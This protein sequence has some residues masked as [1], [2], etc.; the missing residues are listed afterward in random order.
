MAATR[1][2]P[3]EEKIKMD[4]FTNSDFNL[5]MLATQSFNNILEQIQSSCLNFQIQ[6][7]P[8]SAVISLKKSL[9][10]DQ[11]GKPRLPT[12]LDD[13][14]EHV[15]DLVTKNLELERKL[16]VLSNK[17]AE[18]INDFAK[19]KE[20][21]KDL[22]NLSQEACIKVEADTSEQIKLKDLEVELNLVKDIL[23]DRDDEILELEVALKAAKQAS[24]K[25]NS[26]LGQTRAKFE[27]EKALLLKEHRAEVKAWKKDLGNERK[28]RIKIEKEFEKVLGEN[29]KKKNDKKK[30][31]TKP[32]KLKL[33]PPTKINSGI[34]CSICATIIDNFQPDYFCGEMYNP[35]CQTCKAND[36]SWFQDDPFSSFPS[37]SQPPSLVSHWLLTSQQTLPQNPS[38][39][40][41]LV[42]HCAKLPNPGDIFLSME[43]I[44]ELM[45]E[46][47]EEMRD[48]FKL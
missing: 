23:K 37:D 20:T 19:Y 47:F 4:E 6:I 7:S 14:S 8:F 5:T 30:Q 1:T 36:S 2:Q 29:K 41:T 17:H 39:I 35:T 42:S 45:R 43:E 48:S 26:I 22:Q 40:S 9:I 10:R 21:M 32:A 16:I 15:E 3:E 25:T 44:L 38:S 27:S 24:Y 12:K 28:E 18:L 13:T 33:S 46:L 11:S 34:S 31:E